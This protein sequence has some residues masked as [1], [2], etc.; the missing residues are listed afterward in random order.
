M[1]ALVRLA[2]LFGV[3]LF[4]VLIVACNPIRNAA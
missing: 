1:I 4:V 3:P 2:L